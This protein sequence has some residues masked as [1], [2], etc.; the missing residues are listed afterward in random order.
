MASRVPSVSNNAVQKRAV[1]RGSLS[2][3][4]TSGRPWFLNTCSMKSRA[5]PS[6]VMVSAHGA[7][8]TILL[9]RHTKTSMPV[10]RCLFFGNPKTKSML[11]LDHASFGMGRLC[12]GACVL[13][14]D[15]TRWHVVQCCTYASMNLCILG[16][17]NSLETAMTVL[18][19]PMWP[20]IGVLWNS[21]TML[22]RSSSLGGTTTRGRS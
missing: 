19:R 18:S 2:D 5:E 17:Q 10:W 11:I 4:I 1:N 14:V 7:S 13:R 21:Y 12:N 8:L 16:H 20:A 6:A 3:T 15:F 9:R 22:W